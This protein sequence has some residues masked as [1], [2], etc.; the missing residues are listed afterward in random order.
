MG[1]FESLIFYLLIGFAVAAAVWLA[2]GHGTSQRWFA[3]ATAVLFW[4]MYIPMLL[5]RQPEQPVARSLPATQQPADSLSV[6]IAHV[7]AELDAALAS[8]D[9]WAEEALS[10]ESTRIAELKTAWSLQA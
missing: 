1:L 5:S 9:G 6:M 2:D 8:L 3:T 10:R 4:P 7:E